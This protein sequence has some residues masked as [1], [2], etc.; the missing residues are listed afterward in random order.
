MLVKLI[1]SYIA[2]I[3]IPPEILKLGDKAIQIYR[4]ALE[5]GKENIPYFSMLI[6]GKGKVGKTSLFRQL[7]GKPYSKDL[8]STRGIDNDTVYTAE[9]RNLDKYWKLKDELDTSEQFI[10]ALARQ[11]LDTLLEIPA[12]N[13][14]F[15]EEAS[16]ADLLAQ[17]QDFSYDKDSLATA[18]QQAKSSPVA[19]VFDH[20]E[21]PAPENIESPSRDNTESPSQDDTESPSQDNT[22]SPETTHE[23]SEKARNKVVGLLTP[24]Q[25]SKIDQLVSRQHPHEK[26]EPSPV[27]NV[28]DF[29][30][31]QMYRPMHH[32][33]I[34]KRG[35]FVVVFNLSDT[36]KY[37]RDK[38]KYINPL[39]DIRYWIGSI[40]AHI[41]SRSDDKKKRVLLVGTH[42]EELQPYVTEHLQ[43]IDTFIEDN[44]I[45]VGKLAEYIRPLGSKRVCS[46]FIPVENS[47]DI[48]ARGEAYLQES[49]TKDV[50]DEI[51]AMS[52][53]FP[54][55][56]EL[57]PIKWLKFEERLKQCS[58]TRKL[59]SLAP[60]LKIIE[61]KDLAVKSGITNEEQQ[62][63]ALKFFHDTG[64]IVCLS[65]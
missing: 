15:L 61:V 54:Y 3:V 29:A 22:E 20:P 8:D 60:V 63:L 13:S 35:M 39:D 24:Q 56:D 7:V 14:G 26:K 12:E 21:S 19:E 53:V 31:E 2:V 50:Q 62:E 18:D 30:G 48:I 64:K 36:L 33:F 40:H 11:F 46:Y 45:H 42:R 5:E 49:G 43:K 55:L 38:V 16:E 44:L 58:Q 17:L 59:R 41:F 51:M 4:Q 1:L 65:K 9:T 52:R 34:T 6:L 28:L 37:I 47:I 57:H 27:L 25:R 10:N 32:C 23:I